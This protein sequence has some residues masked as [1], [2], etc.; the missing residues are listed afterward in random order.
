MCGAGATSTGT[1]VSLC[2]QWPRTAH[3]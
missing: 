2:L 3:P 1:S